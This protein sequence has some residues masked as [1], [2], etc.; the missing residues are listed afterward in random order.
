MSAPRPQSCCHPPAAGD[1]GRRAC[2]NILSR[3]KSIAIVIGGGSESL[4][5][6]PGTNDIVLKRRQ[7]FVRIALRTGAS[8]VPVYAFGETGTYST[9]TSLPPNSLMRR[10]QSSMLKAWGEPPAA[11]AAAGG[12]CHAP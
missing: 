3:G 4:L 12:G 2:L 1:V 9:L 5:S 7:G 10:L 6:S 8:L 11:P